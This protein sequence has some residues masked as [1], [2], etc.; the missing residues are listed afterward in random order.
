MTHISEIAVVT[1]AVAD[2]ERAE[3][4]YSGAFGYVVRQRG[5]LPAAIGPSWR[6]PP[7]CAGRYVLLGRAGT[8]RGLLRIV[9]FDRP[10]TQI[11]GGYERIQ[12]HGHYAL[13]LRVADV[14]LTWRELLDRGARPKSGPT[15]WNVDATMVAIDSQCWDPD[16]TLL[17][18]YTME[19]RADIF[20]P[21][22]SSA[23]AVETVAVHVE[24]ADRSRD[25]YFGLGYSLF[26]DRRIADLNTFFHLPAGVALR[27]VNL[28][29]PELGY[30]GRIEIVQLEGTEGARVQPR[31]A[32]PNHGILSISFDTDDCDAAFALAL[33]LG[34]AP[35][36]APAEIDWG[37][38]GV[39]RSGTV[40]GP[41][42]E[43]IEFRGA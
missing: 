26:F 21:L 33:D 4:F 6:M 17:D 30:I 18:V 24:N 34:A 16:G 1:I 29:K 22:G 20:T 41:D 31:A 39:Q 40:Y 11:W 32:P 36:A 19:G 13:N 35:C 5:A 9:A 8:Q 28:A 2:L 42:G 3:R 7:G 14:H 25:F 37:P 27:D 10:G 38:A 12:D 43:L 15:R 23:S